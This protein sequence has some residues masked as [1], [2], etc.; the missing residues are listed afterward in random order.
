MK[1]TVLVV[2]CYNEARRLDLD[3]VQNCIRQEPGI[4]FL[5]VND[6]SSDS[7]LEILT[8]F[9]DKHPERVAVRDQ[10]PNQGKA[11]AVRGGMLQAFDRDLDF[12][13]YWDADLATPLDEVPRFLEIFDALPELQIV[14]GS[15]VKL[16]GRNIER[17]NLRHYL[18]RVAATLTSLTLRLEVYDTQCGAKLFRANPPMRALFA[19]PFITGWV[20]DVEIMARLIRDTWSEVGPDAESVIYELPLNEWHD[21]AG[22]KL[23]GRD[24]LTAFIE[25]ARIHR[26]YL[27]RAARL[28]RR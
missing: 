20:F 14:I 15:R 18:G 6:G 19:E 8:G 25:T 24:Y 11:E 21:V 3:R 10:Q 9:A 26:R 5:F 1:R 7:T 16:L 28:E 12:V 27:R 23:K 4:D 2:P 17:S 13:G 22:S